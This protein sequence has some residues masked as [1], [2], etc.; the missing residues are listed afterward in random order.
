MRISAPCKNCPERDYPDC[1]I[2]CPEYLRYQALKE[3]VNE[4][5]RK[6][7]RADEDYWKSRH[8]KRGE[9]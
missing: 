7:N 5:R 6:Q 3:A 4:A 8:T 1:Q 2:M 9:R